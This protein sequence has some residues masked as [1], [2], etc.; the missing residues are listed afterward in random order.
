MR[1]LLEQG[2]LAQ[3]E[4]LRQPVDSDHV[5]LT[6]SGDPLSAVAI[7]PAHMMRPL[8]GRFHEF[9]QEVLFGI[10]KIHPGNV[11]APRPRR[12]FQ[13]FAGPPRFGR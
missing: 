11:N 3:A 6:K 4:L 8:T 7:R 2:L 13:S 5:G 12:Q 10:R 9:A 1:S